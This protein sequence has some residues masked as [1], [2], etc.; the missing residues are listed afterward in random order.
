L[1]YVDIIKDYLAFAIFSAAISGNRPKIHFFKGL[2]IRTNL[3]CSINP[4]FPEAEIIT[5]FA[6]EVNLK[7]EDPLPLFRSGKNFIYG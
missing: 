4:Q 1:Y 3:Q 7:Q 2:A 5:L 6:E